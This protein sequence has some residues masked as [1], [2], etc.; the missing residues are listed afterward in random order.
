MEFEWD[1]AKRRA[2]LAKHGLDLAVARDVF[3]D[4][5]LERLDTRRDYGEDRYVALGLLRGVVVSLVYVE[6]SGRARPISLRKATRTERE[7]YETARRER[8][9]KDFGHDRRRGGP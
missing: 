6:R 3:D 7:F 1:E 9:G 2:N 8:L 5:R 4:Y